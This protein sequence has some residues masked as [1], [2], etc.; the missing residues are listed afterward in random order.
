[1]QNVNG[2]VLSPWVRRFFAIVALIVIFGAGLLI[3]PGVVQP[4]WPWTITPFNAAFLGGVY[5][6]ELVLVLVVIA[7]NRWSPGR[8]IIPMSLCFVTVVTVVSVLWLGKFDSGKWSVPAWF[9]A[10]VGSI[11]IIGYYFL[12]YR[13]L[14]PANPAPPPASWRLL[15][16][17]Q[18]ILLVLYGLGLLLLPA[19]FSSFWPWKIDQPGS[20]LHA[21]MYS[22]VFLTGGLGSLLLSRAAA[23]A[24]Y[25]TL[26]VTEIAL[27]L[28]SIVG[29]ALVDANLKK[30]N[31]FAPGTIL[32]LAIFAVIFG[33]GVGL[34]LKSRSSQSAAG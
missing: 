21:Q 15:L 7:N 19:T 24:E 29:M 14:P 27:G 30:I 16:L 25:L 18:G 33:I 32:W 2:P 17:I 11:V 23:P 28:V 6:S 22:A 4:R 26:G 10:Y 13:N 31:W 5:L 20:A 1:M 12:K 9:I 34:V 3:L 8:L